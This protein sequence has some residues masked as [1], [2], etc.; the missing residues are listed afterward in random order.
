M[1]YILNENYRFRGWYESPTGLY[2]DRIKA[3]RFFP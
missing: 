1:R 3:V 2:D